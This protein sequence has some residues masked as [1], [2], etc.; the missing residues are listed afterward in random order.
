MGRLTSQSTHQ[1][2][3]DL[4]PLVFFHFNQKTHQSP[5]PQRSNWYSM[6]V[7]YC[8][9]LFARAGAEGG[10]IS[11]RAGASY[12]RS[13]RTFRMCRLSAICSCRGG[14]HLKAEFLKLKDEAVSR[15][16]SPHRWM[17]RA[18]HVDGST[19]RTPSIF[20]LCGL[21]GAAFDH[22]FDH[23]ELLYSDIT[24][25]CDAPRRHVALAA[26]SS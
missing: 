4:F 23:M 5:S 21:R 10:N 24:T 25:Y 3:S 17:P 20:W 8:I 13:R 6:Y 14:A 7:L 12:S 18:S 26:G 22:V 2:L 16:W 19:P 9:P 15:P 1:V 11:S